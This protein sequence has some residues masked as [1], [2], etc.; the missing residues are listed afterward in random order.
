MTTR[1]SVFL[2]TVGLLALASGY[3]TRA[4]IFACLLLVIAFASHSRFDG[5]YKRTIFW[6][7]VAG[8]VATSVGMVRFVWKE[9]VPGITE[10]RG[11]ATS[12]RAVSLLREILFAQDAARR[13]AMIDPDGDHIG[14][15]GRLGEL[16]GEDLARGVSILRTPPLASHFA[17]RVGTPSGPASEQEGYLLLICVP[18]K[19][20]AWVTF[21]QAEVDDEKSERNWVAYAW[22]MAAN[23]GHQAAYFINEHEQILEAQN[24]QDGKLRLVGPSAP[25]KCDDATHP[26]TAKLW[27][28]WN[29]KTRRALL[30]GDK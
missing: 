26:A 14:G 28:P 12:K 4:S 10:A 3:E 23:L 20:E 21:P 25:P 7:L 24:I 6:L 2:W 18:G 15:A 29:G 22:P 8:S 5:Q 9:A 13:Y 19:V 11:R 17:P 27:Q 30:P 16:A 1:H